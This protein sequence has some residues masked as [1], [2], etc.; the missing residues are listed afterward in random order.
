MPPE[1]IKIEKKEIKFKGY[2]TTP[3]SGVYLGVLL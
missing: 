1:S 2:V 3:T